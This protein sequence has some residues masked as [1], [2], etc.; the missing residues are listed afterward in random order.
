MAAK[1][2][3]N[4]HAANILEKMA[5]MAALKDTETITAA[6]ARKISARKLILDLGNYETI[7]AG[8]EI[9]LDHQW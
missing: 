6:R 3:V 5:K 2:K 7:K 4:V 9:V 8:L 1:E